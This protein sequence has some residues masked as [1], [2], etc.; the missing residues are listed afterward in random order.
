L[1]KLWHNSHELIR[2]QTLNVSLSRDVFGV[3][4]RV[5]DMVELSV[6][7][8]A[9]VHSELLARRLHTSENDTLAGL[10]EDGISRKVVDSGY[11]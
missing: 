1:R 10:V 3:R 9:K 8:K 5:S 4:D 6:S 7:V 11:F 2:V